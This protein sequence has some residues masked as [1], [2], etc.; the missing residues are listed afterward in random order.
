MSS[1]VTQTKKWSVPCVSL[2]LT[3]SRVVHL[4]DAIQRDLG[5]LE[6]WPH[7]K[8]MRPNK[9]QCKVLY[10]DQENPWAK[11]R[12]QDEGTES[13]PAKKDL[14]VLVDERLDT[15]HKFALAAQKAKR[16]VGHIQRY[17]ANRVR[18][19]IFPLCSALARL[20]L[21]CCMHL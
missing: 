5:K 18:E 20:H 14:R 8:L 17:V 11:D 16:V 19:V 6:E 10:L 9:A 12:L 21:E 1:S 3:Q 13:S 15:S 7:V 4:M 2:Q